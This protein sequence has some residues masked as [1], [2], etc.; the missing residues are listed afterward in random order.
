MWGF[1]LDPFQQ[2]TM[3]D[4]LGVDAAGKFAVTEATLIWPRQ[5]G[6]SFLL[7]GRMLLGL[8]RFGEEMLFSAHEF[9][10]ARKIFRELVEFIRLSPVLGR[11]VDVTD[12]AVVTSG[13]GN[14]AVRVPRFGQGA[15]VP[16]GGVVQF[17]ARSR[18]AA[19]GFTADVVI[20]DEA[21]ILS[22]SEVSAVR[23]VMAARSQHG[24]PQLIKASSAPLL[25]S[26]VLHADRD[27]GIAAH[28]EGTPDGGFMFEEYGSPPGADITAPE[29]WYRVNPSIGTRT[30]LEFYRDSLAGAQAAEEAGA[31]AAWAREFLGVIERVTGVN[32]VDET[33]WEASR[34]P[35]A[36]FGRQTTLGI[37]VSPDGSTAAMALASWADGGQT[38][39]VEVL[40][41]EEGDQWLLT[42]VPAFR[43]AHARRAPVLL[44]ARSQAAAIG[45]QLGAALRG[46]P[47]VH[48]PTRDYAAACGAFAARADAG[49]I[50]HRGD[51]SLDAA[52]AGATK[53]QVGPDM[54]YWARVGALADITPLVA[55]SC[56][57]AGL[58]R[59]RPRRTPDSPAHG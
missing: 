56:A 40:R 46:N 55:V 48:L 47:V 13:A 22:Q 51:P 59:I 25:D 14:E 53:K 4:L 7:T 45:K 50:R 17:V 42:D 29:T 32:V 21:L 10:T 16:G 19:R 24:R 3:V 33:A 34:D 12:S 38:I 41:H 28:E 5:T 36:T 8:F 26:H 9:R 57:V 52:L 37:D 6:K 39:H 49:Q 27:R 20:M 35:E 44:D 18:A 58:L 1:P 11:L 43:R 23:S 31:V 2:D 15:Q 30:S 54:F